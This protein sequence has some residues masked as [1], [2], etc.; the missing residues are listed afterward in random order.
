MSKESL[1]LALLKMRQY[2]DSGATRL[3][4]FRR[5]QLLT[6]RRAVFKYEAEI[7]RALFFDLKKTPE[8]AWVTE[9]GLLLQEISHTLKHLKG[10]MRPERVGTNL[11]NLPS[12]SHV[13]PAPKGIVL[14]VGTWNFPLQL[15]L[16]PFAGA[17]AAGNC[18]VLKPSEHAAATAAIIAKMI[19]EIFPR[20]LALVVEG[21]GAEV[22]P[23]MMTS[24]MCFTPSN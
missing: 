19:R 14:V 17:I 3:F 20:E 8:E 15:L 6:L 7:N 9:T 18:V 13:Y 2:F 11:L 4:S 10:W 5:Q 12:A 1:S 24:F 21:D 22:V 16:I 23:A